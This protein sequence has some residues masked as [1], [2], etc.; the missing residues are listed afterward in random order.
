MSMVL[1]LKEL[2]EY[3]LSI[4]LDGYVTKARIYWSEYSAAIIDDMD[5]G[6]FWS[7]DLSNSLFTINGIKIVGGTELMWPYSQ[8]FGGFMLFDISGKNKD[9]EFSGIGDRWQLNY[10][11]IS[12]VDALRETIGLEVI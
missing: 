3:T 10:Y 2:A 1:P 4:E 8:P 11:S 9:P 5:S 6:G 12:E 7:M